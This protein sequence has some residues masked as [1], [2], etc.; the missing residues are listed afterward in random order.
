MIALTSR[1][2]NLMEAFLDTS[3]NPHFPQE[4]SNMLSEYGGGLLEGV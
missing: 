3:T 1:C 2:E 4:K